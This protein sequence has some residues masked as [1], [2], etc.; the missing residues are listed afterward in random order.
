MKMGSTCFALVVLCGFVGS[1]QANICPMTDQIKQTV[2]K[3]EVEFSADGGWTGSDP[4]IAQAVTGL[5]FEAATLKPLGGGKVQVLCDYTGSDNG[6]RL[7]REGS[8]IKPFGDT[9]NS[10]AVPSRCEADDPVKCQF[11]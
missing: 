1:V 5:K 3:D 10:Q 4:S 11:L 9:W 7:S 6:I 2:G 8:N